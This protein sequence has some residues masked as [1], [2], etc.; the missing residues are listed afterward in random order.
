MV[1]KKEPYD[2]IALGLLRERAPGR[3]FL[4]KLLREGPEEG[5]SEQSPWGLPARGDLPY[6]AYNHRSRWKCQ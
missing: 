3:R 5:R 4:L 1:V 2:R 6:K